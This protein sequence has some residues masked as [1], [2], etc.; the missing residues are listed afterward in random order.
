MMEIQ[1]DALDPVCGMRVSPSK[2]LRS[3]F[4]GKTYFF[5]S[6]GC[7]QKFIDDPTAVLARSSA[8]QTPPGEH[9]CCHGTQKSIRSSPAITALDPE[10]IFTCPMHPEVEHIGPADCPLCGMDL[11]PKFA[12]SAG[13]EHEL[14]AITQMGWR[15]IAAGVIAIPL[16]VLAM[17]EMV[18]LSAG[19]WISPLISGWLQ[20]TLSGAI[21]FGCG[22]PIL[23]RGI[24]SFRT[25]HLNMFSLITVGTLAA[26]FYSFV[27]LL[28]PQWMRHLVAHEGSH[29]PVYFESAGV[30]LCLVLLGQF[31]ELRARRK[32]GSAIREL[33]DLTPPQATVLRAGGEVVV[34][35]SEVSQGDLVRIKPGDKVPVDGEVVEGSAAIDRS[36]LTGESLPD[37]VS[38]GDSVF[39]GTINQSGTLLIRATA[40]GM[41]T[42]VHGIVEL[43]TSAQRSRAPIQKSADI[44]AAYFVPTVII[45]AFL[46]FIGW[47]LLGPQPSWVYGLMS[48]VAVLIIACP[49]AL[50]LATPISV[51]VGLGRGA[52]EGILIKDAEAIERFSKVQTIIFDKTGTLTAGKPEVVLFSPLSTAIEFE[53]LIALAA[54][55]EQRSEHPYATAIVN[56][57]S[58]MKVA[59]EQVEDFASCHG[60]GVIGRVA[61]RIAHIGSDSFLTQHGIQPASDVSSSAQETA[62]EH[63]SQ[64][65]TVLWLAIDQRREAMLVLADQVKPSAREALTALNRIGIEVVML[66]GDH[67]AT[68]SSV[69]QQLGVRHYQA[70]LSPQEK[71]QTIRRYQADGRIVAMV[72]D[73]INDAPALAL[74]DVGI[75]MGSGAGIAIESAD[76]ILM[77]SDLHGVVRAHSLSQKTMSNIRQ[78]LFFAFFYNALGIPLAAG[79]FYPLV[80]WLLSPMFAAAAMSLSSLS[81]IT[82]AL[83][84]RRVRLD[85]EPL[86]TAGH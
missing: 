52:K 56:Y 71:H 42:I 39:A 41:K 43:I 21:L 19:R 40:V 23:M 3:T 76:M 54:S 67:A 85:E 44:A 28:F 83:R 32:T 57:A 58:R 77:S 26:F 81:V 29:L 27:V 48:A 70:G 66:T 2:A 63:L 51:T 72:G 7:Q 20:A 33:L 5:C 6:P 80:G 84:L 53:T 30:I 75:A 38:F 49:C 12:S 8:G 79:I 37:D 10:A 1:I 65:H 55:V 47:G 15:T 11:E 60:A 73:G 25:G 64:G 50:G 16:L 13:D 34:P 14:A 22:G 62:A 45:V 9:S 74:A 59:C 61:G 36:M 86:V 35:L 78:N 82:N 17:G 18:G 69:A 24:A 31:L 46:T 4:D 68:A